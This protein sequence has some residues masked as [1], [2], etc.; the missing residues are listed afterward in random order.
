MHSPTSFV[1]IGFQ[2]SGPMTPS[3]GETRWVC[4]TSVIRALVSALYMEVRISLRRM[5][6]RFSHFS[7]LDKENFFLIP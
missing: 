4:S 5:V 3:D 2:F 6:L 1:K 7:S